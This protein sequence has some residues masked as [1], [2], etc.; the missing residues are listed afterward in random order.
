M[1][2]IE[3]LAARN[4]E[5]AAEKFQPELKMLPHGRAV[6]IGCVDPR[7]DPVEIFK[8]EQG[9]A[10][11]IRNVGGRVNEEIVET[12]DI[13][14]TVAK[15]AG[16]EVGEGWNLVVLHH[17][18]CG[19]KGCYKHAPDLLAK[20]MQVPTEKLEELEV[21]DPYKAVEIDV[22]ALKDASKV[23]SGFTVSGLVYDVATGRFETVV[24]PTRLRD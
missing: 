13:L 8:L 17:T 19:I 18:D 6:I 11:V 1:T 12:I 15:V 5:F 14:G 21:M 2:Y 23:P 22:K 7:V 9:E 4:A 20:Y 16:K 24:P 3:S 10:A